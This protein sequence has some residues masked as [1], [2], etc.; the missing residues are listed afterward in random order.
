MI[1]IT[2]YDI[3]NTLLAN[4]GDTTKQ[5]YKKHCLAFEKIEIINFNY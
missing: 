4:N 5:G 1:D 3:Q 2:S